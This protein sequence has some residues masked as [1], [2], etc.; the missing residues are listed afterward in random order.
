MI[1]KDSRHYP[2]TCIICGKDFIGFIKQKICSSECRNS[3]INKQRSLFAQFLSNSN[4]RGIAVTLTQKDYLS[5]KGESCYY[6]GETNKIGRDRKDSRGIYSLEN[7]VPS[8]IWCNWMKGLM[9]PEIFIQKCNMIA[10]IHPSDTNIN[11]Q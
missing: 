10:K 5:L 3:E 2:H 11:S 9:T 1:K 6:C 7:T 4:R 8:C